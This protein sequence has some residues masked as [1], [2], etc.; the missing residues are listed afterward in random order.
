MRMDR[1]Y[2]IPPVAPDGS[3][4][5][6]VDHGERIEL[7][8]RLGHLCGATDR[9]WRAAGSARLGRRSTRLRVKSTG[10]P[11]RGPRATISSFTSGTRLERVRIIVGPPA[12]RVVVTCASIATRS[13]A[14]SVLRLASPGPSH[15]PGFELYVLDARG[16]AG[17][18]GFFRRHRSGGEL[19]LPA[20]GLLFQQPALR[21]RCD[22]AANR[23][24]GRARSNGSR[25]SPTDAGPWRW[26][27]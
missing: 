5:V 27:R 6:R 12:M 14:A 23:H 24:T 26:I 2:E 10:S 3:R 9:Q 7:R 16:P 25:N 21:D 8:C 17:A 15:R 11:P 18:P 22:G 4:V 20:R 1:S 19:Y 13:L